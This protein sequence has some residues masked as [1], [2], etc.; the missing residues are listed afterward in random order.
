MLQSGYRHIDE[1]WYLDYFEMKMVY[2][3]GYGM[4]PYRYFF[5]GDAD[6]G[7]EFSIQETEGY[8]HAH[9]GHVTNTWRVNDETIAAKIAWELKK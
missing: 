1:F 7:H 8:V 6:E 4:E 5:T 3:R 2:K 9:R